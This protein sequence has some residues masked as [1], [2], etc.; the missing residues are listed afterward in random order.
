MALGLA[1]Y[2]PWSAVK[3]TIL[4]S[5]WRRNPVGTSDQIHEFSSDAI[6]FAN[7]GAQVEAGD[8]GAA[9]PTR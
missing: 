2:G 4:A 7:A 1:V 6:H 3:S 9:P 5:Y 8:I